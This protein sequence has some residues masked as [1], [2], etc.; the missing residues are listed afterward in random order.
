MA[1][2]IFGFIGCGN[3]GGAMASAGS[4]AVGE[5]VLLSNRTPDKAPGLAER[6]GA[7][8]SNNETVAARESDYLFLGVKPQMMADMLAGIR[9]ALL[10]R[11]APCVLVTMAAGLS[12][13]TIRDMAGR[14]YP[15]IRIN[16]NTPWAVAR[17]W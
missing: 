17:A 15:V 1:N 12:I 8:A 10:A 14:D 7:R 11:S 4:R 6:L 9:E 5:G 2:E 3:M 16:P 13:D